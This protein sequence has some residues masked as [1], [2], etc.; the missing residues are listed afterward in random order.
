MDY[1][2]LTSRGILKEGDLDALEIMRRVTTMGTWGGSEL[3]KGSL[4]HITSADSFPA[5]YCPSCVAGSLPLS[6]R[7]EVRH[8]PK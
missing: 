8:P 4:H 7:L 5:S 6:W 2:R 1:Q 3:F